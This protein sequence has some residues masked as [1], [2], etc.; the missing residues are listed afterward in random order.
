MGG[1]ILKG[2][3]NKKKGLRANFW[4]PCLSLDGFFGVSLEGD[5]LEVEVLPD[6]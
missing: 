1:P 5:C 4:S 3:S 2:G 6:L